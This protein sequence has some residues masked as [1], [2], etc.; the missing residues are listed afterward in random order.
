MASLYQM[1]FKYQKPGG[2]FSAELN[3]K[4]TTCT[5]IDNLSPIFRILSKIV[6]VT[7][8]IILYQRIECSGGGA[9]CSNFTAVVGGRLE[10]KK[11]EESVPE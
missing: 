5:D 1:L 7:Q 8:C 10:V 11:K 2:N 6:D 4:G 9:N 3:S